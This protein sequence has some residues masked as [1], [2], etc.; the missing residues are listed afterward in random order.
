MVWPGDWSLGTALTAP[1]TIMG[2]QKTMQAQP[3]LS[4]TSGS[5]PGGMGRTGSSAKWWLGSR[6]S[7]DREGNSGCVATHS[8]STGFGC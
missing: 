2:D 5:G 4:D 7:A 6:V 3:T 8:G 1:L